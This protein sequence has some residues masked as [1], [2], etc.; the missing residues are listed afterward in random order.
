M[1]AFQSYHRSTKWLAWVI[2]SK[3]FES[4]DEVAM[5]KGRF[6]KEILDHLQTGVY[7]VDRDRVITYWNRGAERLSGFV[8]EK[9]IGHSCRENILI[10]VDGSGRQLCT[11]ACP[12]AFT[13]HDG[14]M[15]EADV[16]M[17]HRDGHR[18]P[19][20]VRVTPLYEDGEIV[21]A[22]EVFYDNS[23][24]IA[25]LE[26]LKQMEADAM[27][28]SLTGVGNRRYSELYLR[29]MLAE[30]SELNLPMGLVFVDIDH[31]K[32]INDHY[33][34]A[35]GDK[36]LVMVANTLRHALKSFDYIGRWGGEE[37]VI[38]L[39]NVDDEGLAQT[40]EHL[41]IQVKTSLLTGD[42]LMVQATVSLGATLARAGDDLEG[43][44]DRADRLMYLSKANGRDQVTQG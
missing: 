41:R 9:V 28:D 42:D 40:A 5:D 7:F 29:K 12:L 36:V 22:V 13:L 15:R 43:L 24:K 35:V 4:S 33:G 3:L 38:A 2:Y 10:H 18:V 37:F 21:G 27:L 23:S 6:Y 39:A 44:V 17:H 14:Q 8:G 32:Q 1:I 16:Y 30:S 34:H 26:R 20:T 25:V 31:F 11:S 19:V